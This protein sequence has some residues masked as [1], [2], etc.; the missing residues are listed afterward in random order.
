MRSED[1]V[2]SVISVVL[3][4]GIVVILGAVVSVFALGIGESVDS[5]AP[6]ATFEFEVQANGDVQVT[7][8]SGD[9][10]DGDQLRFA[11]AALE[12]TSVGSI[13]EWSGG[14]V[15]AGDSATVNAKGGDT[16]RLIWQSPKDDT[17]GTIAQYDV[18]NSAN[19]QASIG[20]FGYP[21][22]HDARINGKV[23]IKNL[24]FSRAHDDRVYVT[25]EDE[26]AGGSTSAARYFDSSG[27]DLIFSDA[28]GSGL[29]DQNIGSS[30]TITVTIYETDK[31]QVR[32]M[33]ATFVT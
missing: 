22:S 5:T 2:S 32:V 30:E 10:F 27:D 9:S 26:P 20:G 24:Q 12:K 33:T 31:K 11:G 19:P 25:V 15:T 17:T 3:M 29:T 16:L 4:V 28:T 1:A 21:A 23:T 8:A 6:S 18:P 7:H 13:N 14:D